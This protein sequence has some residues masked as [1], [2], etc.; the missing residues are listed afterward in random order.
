MIEK[1]RLIGFPPKGRKGPHI[2]IFL[3]KMVWK[4]MYDF[5]GDSLEY[6]EIMRN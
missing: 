5:S 6:L 4:D 2:G 3:P 1:C